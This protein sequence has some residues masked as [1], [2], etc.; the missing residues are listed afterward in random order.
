MRTTLTIDD[1][2]AGNLKLEIRRSGRTLKEAV[3][4]LL[5]RGLAAKDKAPPRKRFVVHA[6][7][8]GRQP[9]VEYDSVSSL[10]E[11]LEGPDHR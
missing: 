10:L 7:D 1:D 11:Q 2:V 6:R 4:D 8:L 9:G 5:R 3:N